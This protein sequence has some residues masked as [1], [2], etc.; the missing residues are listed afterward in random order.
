MKIIV[1]TFQSTT[2]RVSVRLRLQR[3][4]TFLLKLRWI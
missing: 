1:V 3:V 2:G 4:V